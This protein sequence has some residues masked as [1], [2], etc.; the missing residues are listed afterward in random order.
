[1]AQFKAAGCCT[2]FREK[3]SGATADRHPLKKLMTKLSTGDVTVT[4]AVDR[5]SRDSADL[6]V[7]ARDIQRAGAGVQFFAE[8]MLAMRWV[9]AK[10]ERRHIM[11]RMR[12]GSL[13]RL[14]DSILCQMIPDVQGHGHLVRSR[15]GWERWGVTAAKDFERGGI[16]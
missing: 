15:V 1:M 4:P 5:L 14:P 10:L 11:E 13:I 8:L 12:S 7:I 6:L 2:I 16:Q 9:A 3:I